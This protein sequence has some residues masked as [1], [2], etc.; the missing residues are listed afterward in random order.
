MRTL[1]VAKEKKSSMVNGTLIL[2]IVIV[3]VSY[4][5]NSRSSKGVE[6]TTSN[7]LVACDDG[8]I[9]TIP[10]EGQI[11]ECFG[12]LEA[13]IVNTSL[14][15]HD[16]ATRSAHHRAIVDDALKRV[17]DVLVMPT[18]ILCNNHVRGGSGPDNWSLV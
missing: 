12:H 6:K 18:S 11:G 2:T 3:K 14:Y 15:V 7:I 17:G 16:Q 13:L 10:K 4:V 9:D 8:D 1:Y 5:T